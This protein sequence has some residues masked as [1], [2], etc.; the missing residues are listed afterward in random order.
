MQINT[1]LE[2]PNFHGVWNLMVFCVQI[3]LCEI[4][5][6]APHKIERNPHKNLRHRFFNENFTAIPR[7]AKPTTMYAANIA[8]SEANQSIIRIT[9][10]MNMVFRGKKFFDQSV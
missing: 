3:E 9:P 7:Q 1:E 8:I 6:I 2:G 10:F 4:H 5:P